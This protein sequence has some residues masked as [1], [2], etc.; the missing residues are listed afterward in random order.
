[1]IETFAL[2]SAIHA[3]ALLPSLQHLGILP[4]SIDLL[5]VSFVEVRNSKKKRKNVM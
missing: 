2:L 4:A 5:L 1:M 3:R